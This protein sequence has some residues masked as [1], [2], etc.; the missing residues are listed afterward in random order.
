[1]GY[2]RLPYE[3]YFIN[4]GRDYSHTGLVTYDVQYV[5]VRYTTSRLEKLLGLH[6]EANYEIHYEPERDVIQLNFQWTVGFKDWFANIFEFSSKYYDAIVLEGKPLQLRVHHGWG[7]MYKAIKWEVRY[8]WQAYHDEH[9]TAHTEVVGW[10]LGS[11]IAILCAQDL[12]YNY[13]VK[14]HLYTYGSVKP[15]KYTRKN[16]EETLDYLSGLCKSCFNFSDVNDL[17]TYMPPFRGFTE[18]RRVDLGLEKRS[19]LRLLRPLVYHTHYYRKELYYKVPKK[20]S[21]KSVT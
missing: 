11:A 9:P 1:M 16:K 6:H 3:Q 21:R 2:K 17:I 14:T 5:S 18:I 7:D 13:G 20:P 19:V 10:S 15:F 4:T 12:N 8:N